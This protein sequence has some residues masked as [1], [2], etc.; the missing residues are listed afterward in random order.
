MRKEEFVDHSF[1]SRFEKAWKNSKY[2]HFNQKELGKQ[3]GYCHQAISFFIHGQRYPEI[4]SGIKIAEELNVSI[5]YL[6]TGREPIR[7][8]EI[9]PFTQLGERLMHL[10]QEQVEI[11]GW[12][13][14]LFEQ[15]Q[16]SAT[17]LQEAIR[18]QH[19]VD[20]VSLV[21]PKQQ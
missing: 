13:V 4:K 14:G 1:G 15:N 10:R 11:L 8:W 5:D 19:H 16:L 3:L 9:T 21:M 6:Y 18:Q 7:P 20:L 12:L 17:E 2:C